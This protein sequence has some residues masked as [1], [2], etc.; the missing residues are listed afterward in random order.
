MSSATSGPDGSRCTL[1]RNGSA[2]VIGDRALDLLIALVERAD[3][4]VGVR[5]LLS[6]V[7]AGLR[8]E[9]NNVRVQL[10]SLRRALDDTDSSRFISNVQ[11]RGYRFVHSLRTSQRQSYSVCGACG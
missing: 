5:E 10:A 8:V 6:I 3:R 1:E 7:W 2:I 4:V 9:E 11:G